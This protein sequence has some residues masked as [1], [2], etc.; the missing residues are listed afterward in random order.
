MAPME[1]EISPEAQLV[2]DDA[3]AV[4][5]AVGEVDPDL[6]EAVASVIEDALALAEPAAPAEDASVVD[7]EVVE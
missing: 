6:A 5:A 3:A 1:E 2:L 4:V 7:A